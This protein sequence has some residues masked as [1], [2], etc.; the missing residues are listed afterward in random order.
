L[1]VRYSIFFLTNEAAD[2]QE[3]I[4]LTLKGKDSKRKPHPHCLNKGGE[5]KGGFRYANRVQ[6][7]KPYSIYWSVK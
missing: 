4:Y 2:L 3:G 6:R 5:E 1:L 7:L